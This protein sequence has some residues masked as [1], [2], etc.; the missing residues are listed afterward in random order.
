MEIANLT[1]KLIQYFFMSYRLVSLSAVLLERDIP[2][3][4]LGDNAGPEHWEPCDR[5]SSL[6]IVTW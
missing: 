5:N 3:T 4:C 1:I 6:T 2:G